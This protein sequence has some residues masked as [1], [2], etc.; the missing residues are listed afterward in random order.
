MKDLFDAIPESVA[1]E[2]VLE[3]EA[4]LAVVPAD[5]DDVI[6]PRTEEELHRLGAT[7]SLVEPGSSSL[8]KHLV[9]TFGP[10]HVD[11][12][13]VVQLRVEIDGERLVTV[14]PEIGWLHQ[15]L[16]KLL[17][18]AS[19]TEGFAL[20]VRTS[21]DRPHFAVVAWALAIERL[22]D[23]QES[24]PARAVLWRTIVLEIARIEAHLDVLTPLVRA[25]ADRQMTA[26]FVDVA[27]KVRALLELAAP[28]SRAGGVLAAF[29]GLTT[30]IAP[31]VVEQLERALP[32]VLAPLRTA[33]DRL[34]LTPSF[35]DALQGLGVLSREDAL[36]AGITGPALR[37]TGLVDD[38]RVTHPLLAYARVPPRVSTSQGGG[39]LARFRVRLDEVHASSAL[40]L[41]ALAAWRAQDGPCL[42]TVT[43]DDETV[44]PR[45][46]ATVSLEAPSGELSLLVHGNGSTRL[47]RAHMKSPSF[48][49]VAALPRILSGARLDEV[50]TI[51]AG[52][53][54]ALTEV[55][56]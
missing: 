20:I 39:A 31:S 23:L 9:W 25:H 32:E 45:R 29:G 34:S 33:G 52:L 47:S 17:E 54:I 41:R 37:A 7:G 19:L 38:L 27:R 8:A 16:E 18:G 4:P 21:V 30:E 56:R 50:S 44:L 13:L 11:L 15:G 35:V 26:T 10:H 55:D 24:V 49:L 12:P 53:G 46:L 6:R 40:V 51:L 2:L 48:A 5:D 42:P 22:L 1:S 28:P 3:G 14:D 43:V 36:T